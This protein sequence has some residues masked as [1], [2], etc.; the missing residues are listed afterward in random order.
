MGKDQ[1]LLNKRAEKKKELCDSLK[2]HLTS[3]ITLDERGKVRD[4]I[5]KTALLHLENHS[6]G[7]DWS[8]MMPKT[9]NPILAAL[10]IPYKIERD[11]T[12]K[13]TNWIVKQRE[14]SDEK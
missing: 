4:L 10:N 6:L 7:N 2:K 1:E 5:M 12:P 14:T 9:L 8:S 3:P 11:S 13:A